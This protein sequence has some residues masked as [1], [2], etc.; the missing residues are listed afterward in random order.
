MSSRQRVIKTPKNPKPSL[1]APAKHHGGAARTILLVEDS[2]DDE[3][4]FL[5]LIR[6]S[7]LPNPV[8]VVRDGR[9]AIAYLNREGQF[10]D[11]TTYPLPSAMFLDL[12]M[13]KV[14]GFEVLR[15]IKTQPHLEDTLRIILTHHQEVR[16]VRQAYELGA[17]SFLTKPLS[18]AELSSL[19][20]HFQP[21]FHGGGDQASPAD[22][23]L[24]DSLNLQ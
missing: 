3:Y 8:M 7:R 19:L 18:H 21:Y 10:A 11:A 2:A 23:G 20:R 24:A 16:D 1:S 9:E 17:H 12:K 22:C 6:R 5:E 14:G 4:I 13:P 15:W